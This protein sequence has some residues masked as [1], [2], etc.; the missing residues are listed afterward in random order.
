MVP[1]TDPS[2]R[3]ESSHDSSVL[4]IHLLKDLLLEPAHV[5]ELVGEPVVVQLPS[6]GSQVK[7]VVLCP[8]AKPRNMNISSDLYII[9]FQFQK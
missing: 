4:H 9:V 5:M 8:L 6:V 7:Q 1:V 3:T 2:L